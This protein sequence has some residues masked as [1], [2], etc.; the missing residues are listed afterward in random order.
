MQKSAVQ[1]VWSVNTEISDHLSHSTV[2]EKPM[3]VNSTPNDALKYSYKASV[4][5]DASTYIDNK[6]SEYIYYPA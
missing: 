6:K 1:K 2:Y 5:G 4:F 3:S